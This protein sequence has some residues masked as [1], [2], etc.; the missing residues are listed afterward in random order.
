MSGLLVRISRVIWDFKSILIFL[1]PIYFVL[2]IDYT[3][4][5]KSFSAYKDKIELLSWLFSGIMSLLGFLSLFIAFIYENKVLA[6]AKTYRKIIMPYSLTEQELRENLINYQIYTSNNLMMLTLHWVFLI[7]STIIIFVWGIS[8]GLYTKFNNPFVKGYGLGEMLDLGVYLFLGVL[9]VSMLMI[10]IYIN[11]IKIKHDPLGKDYLPKYKSLY[12]FDDLIKHESAIDEYFTVNSPKLTIYLNPPLEK[13]VYEV[14]FS[15]PI[16]LENLRFVLKVY[17]EK[18]NILTCYGVVCDKLNK[19]GENYS[20]IVD[21]NMPESIYLELRERTYAEIKIYNRHSELSSR[22][23]LLKNII[24]DDTLEFVVHRP[25]E[26]RD[27]IDNDKLYVENLMKH[28]T[29]TVQIKY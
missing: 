5:S 13:P 22:L 17:T 28:G 9:S 23:S 24:D 3:I 11:F 16:R 18:K 20:M 12:N 15:L 21:S 26:H 27:R 7:F 4:D 2:K 25:I 8:I 6:A 19:Y 29:D 14:K 10:S 1:I